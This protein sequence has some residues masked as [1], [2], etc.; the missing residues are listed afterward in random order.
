MS[1]VFVPDMARGA[2][3]EYS[4]LRSCFP[5]DGQEAARADSASLRRISFSNRLPQASQLYS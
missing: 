4:C 1:E 3:V 5:Q 2:K